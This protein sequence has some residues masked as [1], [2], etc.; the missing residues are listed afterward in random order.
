MVVKRLARG[1]VA[2]VNMTSVGILKAP[3]PLHVKENHLICPNA[4]PTYSNIA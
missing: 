1:C 3:V 2:S 4:T